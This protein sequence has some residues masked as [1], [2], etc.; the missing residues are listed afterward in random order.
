MK[1]KPTEKM[2]NARTL[3]DEAAELFRQGESTDYVITFLTGVLTSMEKYEPDKTYPVTEIHDLF[4]M[5]Y[6]KVMEKFKE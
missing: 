4:E 3:A 5:L 2:G 6:L 1:K